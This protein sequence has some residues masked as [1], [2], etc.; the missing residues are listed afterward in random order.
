[1]TDTTQAR[2]VEYEGERI[3]LVEG[4]NWEPGLHPR[5]RGGEFINVLGKL[6]RKSSKPSFLPNIGGENIT[7]DFGKFGERRVTGHERPKT[8]RGAAAMGYASSTYRHGSSPAMGVDA[9][10]MMGAAD[11]PEAA[12]DSEQMAVALKRSIGDMPISEISRIIRLDWG[13]KVNYAARPYLDAMGSLSSASD[14]YGLDSGSSV[15]NYFL[16]NATTYRGPVAR[17]VKAEL[18]KRVGR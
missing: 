16:S 11:H 8:G 4:A 6:D 12:T 9:G 18:K 7:P 3:L 2:W 15:I 13:G 10:P 14:S 1:M 17:V 5:G